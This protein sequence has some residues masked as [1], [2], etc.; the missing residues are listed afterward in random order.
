MERNMP[1]KVRHKLYGIGEV[2]NSSDT[3]VYV[4]FGEKRRS[5]DI[6]DAFNKGFLVPIN[7]ETKELKE[8]QNDK[9]IYF[10]SASLKKEVKAKEKADNKTGTQRE[11]VLDAAE[12][13]GYKS[14]Y[15]ALNAALGTQYTGWMRGT[16]PQ[17]YSS[18]PFR[19]WLPKLAATKNGKLVS[20]ANK[21]VNT[22]SDDWNE[23]VYDDL[24][25]TQTEFEIDPYPGCT[26]VF[27]KEPKNGP[28]IF[29]G[30]F[31]PDEEKSWANHFVSKRVATRVKLIGQPASEIELL[32]DNRV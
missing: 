12:K 22:I 13:I 10:K 15:E 7:E 1:I 19:I 28:Y 30:A 5:F 9:P 4:M 17:K 3:K 8:A 26:L 14:I 25:N 24:K 23:I 31:R 16:W 27:A 2:I 11:I 29:R 32:D 6:P 18:M 20:A 21:C